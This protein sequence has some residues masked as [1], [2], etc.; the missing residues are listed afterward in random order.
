MRTHLTCIIA[1]I[2]CL[3]IPLSIDAAPARQLHQ[4]ADLRQQ[5][6]NDL[7]NKKL[8]PS[9]LLYADDAI[10]LSP[11][12]GRFTGKD[13]IRDLYRKVFDTFDSD[14]QLESKQVGVSGDMAFDS[15]EYHE[16]LMNRSTKASTT[17]SGS[18]VMILK[19]QGK[20]KWQIVQHVWT[21]VQPTH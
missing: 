17:T 8:E 19:R 20:G 21:E 14:I 16:V 9:M 3:C 6:A 2:V 11:D 1:L 18:Y 4:I 12:G 7:H 5:W 10:F 15:G 13:A